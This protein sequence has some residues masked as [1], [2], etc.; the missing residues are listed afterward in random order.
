MTRSRYRFIDQPSYTLLRPPDSKS[1]TARLKLSSHTTACLG[2]LGIPYQ[3]TLIIHLFI[4]NDQHTH[5][6]IYIYI[7]IIYIYVYI[8]TYHIHVDRRPHNSFHTCI[9]IPKLPKMQDSAIFQ[10]CSNFAPFFRTKGKLRAAR[11]SFS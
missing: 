1:T 5:T 7:V 4:H 8:N 3:I 10:N 11:R 2:H 6:Y 9:S